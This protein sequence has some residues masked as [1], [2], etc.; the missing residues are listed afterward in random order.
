M[1]FVGLVVAVPVVIGYF[2]LVGLLGLLGLIL[3]TQ[4]GLKWGDVF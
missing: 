1:V 2:I 3:Y 4:I